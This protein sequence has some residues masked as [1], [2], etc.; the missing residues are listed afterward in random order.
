[1]MSKSGNLR[2]PFLNEMFHLAVPIDP[3]EELENME[4]VL[5]IEEGGG[6]QKKV[7][8]DSNV[9][10]GRRR[11]HAECESGSGND[12]SILVR[13][14]E[15]DVNMGI[16]THE[17]SGSHLH[18]TIPYSGVL[19]L[20]RSSVNKE[21]LTVTVEARGKQLEYDEDTVYLSD[22]SL[23]DLIDRN[24]LF[25][26]PFY[27]FNLEEYF[28]AFEKED[29]EAAAR[30]K[31]PFDKMLQYVNDQYNSGKLSLAQYLLVM[32]MIRK[33]A[34]NLSKKHEHVRKELD[35]IV[36]GRVIEFEGE[37]LLREG[38]KIGVEKGE[39][40]GEK[41]GS[42]KTL[43]GLVYDK[44]LPFEV[45]AK[46]AEKKFGTSEEEFRKMVDSYTPDDDDDDLM[47]G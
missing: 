46:K 6:R 44:D 31:K 10:I 26:F 27:I 36:G 9:K 43:A 45:A 29:P 33:V 15:Y 40:R 39:K 30:V 18:V 21:A 4:N 37:Q 28:E 17:L 23:Q 12:D 3:E 8:T 20:R 32:D 7:I 11:F 16:K 41:K 5:F 42:L 25:L 19:F 47:E 13:M 35:K 14:F 2:I 34:D 38:E 24:L 22:Y 1:M